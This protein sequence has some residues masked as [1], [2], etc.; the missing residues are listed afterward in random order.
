MSIYVMFYFY[1]ANEFSS[2][3][4]LSFRMFLFK[5]TEFEVMKSHDIN[6]KF[7]I[8]KTFAFVHIFIHSFREMNDS[9]FSMRCCFPFEY[10]MCLF[11]FDFHS[12][13]LIQIP[14]IKQ[15]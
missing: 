8:V 12:L 10:A 2:M 4:S 5:R 7:V 6:V 15:F 1:I 3:T 11:T 9:M 14:F 13:N